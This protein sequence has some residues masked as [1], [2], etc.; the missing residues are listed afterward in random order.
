[1]DAKKSFVSA[2]RMFVSV[3]PGFTVLARMPRGARVSA[4][5]RMKPT[6]ACFVA[7]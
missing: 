5:E 7:S 3:M 2:L 6:T 1:M 4:T